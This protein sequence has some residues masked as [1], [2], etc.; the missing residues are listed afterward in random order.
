M[1]TLKD[2]W[3]NKPAYSIANRNTTPE[4]KESTE[5]TAE[6]STSPL[7]EPPSSFVVDQLHP[8]SAEDAEAQLNAALYLTTQDN[9]HQSPTLHQSFQG[10]DSANVLSSQSE[11]LQGS[12]RIMKDGKEVVI[13]S[14]G[15]DT[16]S[17]CS[18]DDP[19]TLFAPKSTKKAEPAP[20]TFTQTIKSPKKY[21]HT[22]DSL[23][24]DAVD[25]LETEAAVSRVRATYA[26]TQSNG[27]ARGLR[28]SS[29]G[30]ALNESMLISA[31]DEDEDGVSGQRLIGAIRR[32]DAL[33]N[34]RAWSFFD[35]TQP[36]PPAP[37]LSRDL[38]APGSSME[39]LMDSNARDRQFISGQF[40]QM[41][42]SKGLLPDEFVL[43]MFHSVPYER[44]ENLSNAYYR[45][46]KVC[47]YLYTEFPLE[48]TN[49]MHKNM[50]VE[51][52]RSLIRPADIDDLFS[53][54]GARPQALD[55]SQKTSPDSFQSITPGSELKDHLVSVFRL[56][57]ETAGLFAEDTQEKVILLLLRLTLD[58]SLT[59]DFTLS[60]E[61]QR[62]IN[63][64]LDPVNFAGFN[65]DDMLHRVF[66]TCYNTTDDV[67]LQSHIVYHILPTSPWLA[68]LRCRLAVSFLLRSPEPL[69]EPPEK[70][71]DLK[72]ITMLLLRDERFQVKKLKSVVDY[73]WRELNALAGLL[74]TAIDSSVLELNYRGD[75]TEKDYNTAI[76]R[77]AT[78]VKT[79]FCSIQ[80]SGASH[81]TRTVA[82]SELEAL[83]YRIVYSVRSKPPP[84]KGIFESHVSEKDIRSLFSNY[85]AMAGKPVPELLPTVQPSAAPDDVEDGDTGLPIRAHDQILQSPGRL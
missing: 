39:I 84:K 70:V 74:N 37:E 46:L 12:Q 10:V 24:H 85:A 30:Y 57:Q 44:R 79:I 22:I 19:D 40:I 81:V 27:G 28:A 29:S 67:C 41:L 2:L 83:H 32:T 38:F 6:S 51:R 68:L 20:V 31:L 78:Q 14:D 65:A 1:R 64:V 4:K 60:S 42:M 59:T 25:D 43:W 76:D 52:L 7:T 55:S 48:S 18:L 47:Q 75:R 45:I 16:D 56:L 8:E 34:A 9:A 33:D 58:A 50:D 36:L 49:A 73:D 82:K 63:A 72:R 62:T 5:N 53:R 61:L 54:L 66:L 71:L 13:S 3:F 77:L 17:I 35:S 26:Q 21:R 80:D 11:S 15:E 69:T 23:V